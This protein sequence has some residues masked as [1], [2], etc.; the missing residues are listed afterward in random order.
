MKPL[1]M[2]SG[3]TKSFGGLSVLRGVDL[4]I[5]AGEILG[6]VGANGAGKSTFVDIVAG[7][8]SANGGEIW[9][10]EKPLIGTASRRAGRGLARTFQHPQLA[11]DMSLR[12]NIAVGRSCDLLASRI[13]IAAAAAMGVIGR[14][15]ATDDP[16][17]VEIASKL[18]LEGLDRAAQEVSF[19]ELRLVEVARALMQSPKLLILDEPFSGVGDTGTAGIITA[20]KSARDCGCAVLLIDH[21]VD[22][23]AHAVDRIALLLQ[24]TIAVEGGVAECMRN[25]VFRNTYIGLD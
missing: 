9:L 7:V 10:A 6:L 21:N 25:P 22:L 19:G 1:F 4:F 11:L 5:Q 2:T 8:Q 13:Q 20:L 14:S 15:S 23:L 16:A 24:G 3:V 12:E 17:I 18:G